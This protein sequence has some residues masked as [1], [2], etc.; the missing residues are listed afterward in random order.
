MR[1]RNFTPHPIKYVHDDGTFETFQSEGVARLEFIPVERKN[2]D[3]YM[4]V[5]VDYG[6]PIDL[7]P[8]QSN[9][10]LI[11]SMLVKS[12]VKRSDLIAPTHT[13]KNTEGHVV[14]CRAFGY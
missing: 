6:Q 9:T 13:V 1:I 14:G 8:K 12:H 11:V 2:F 10:F 4:F 5:K 7:P 3:G